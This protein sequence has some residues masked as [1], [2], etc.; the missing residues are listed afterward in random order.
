MCSIILSETLQ[1]SVRYIKSDDVICEIIQ[2]LKRKV[3]W[4]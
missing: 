2:N 4:V 1:G 3:V